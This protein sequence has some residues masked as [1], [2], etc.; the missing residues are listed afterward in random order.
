MLNLG[1]TCRGAGF[2][3]QTLRGK[4]QRCTVCRAWHYKHCRWFIELEMQFYPLENAPVT[5][6]TRSGLGPFITSLPEIWSLNKNQ[7]QPIT[8]DYSAAS[9]N[10]SDWHILKTF[11]FGTPLLSCAART[12]YSHQGE[13]QSGNLPIWLW[14]F[15]SLVPR[16][17]L[18]CGLETSFS[19][20]INRFMLSYSMNM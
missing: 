13:E 4:L 14:F 1:L 2:K 17:H 9:I 16:P 6:R 19:C 12:L 10:D 7:K 3:G 11:I 5:T 8:D 18:W 20:L 15:I